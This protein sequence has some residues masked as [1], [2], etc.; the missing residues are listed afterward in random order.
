VSGEIS[1]IWMFP[2]E[3]LGVR[4]II[5]ATGR[6]TSTALARRSPERLACYGL[7]RRRQLGERL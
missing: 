5:V 6:V 4:E 7:D 3:R 1:G 2:V